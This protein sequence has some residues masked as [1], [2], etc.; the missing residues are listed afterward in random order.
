MRNG[1]ATITAVD[2]IGTTL[3]LYVT[4]SQNLASAQWSALEQ[5]MRTSLCRGN[6]ASMIAQGATVTYHILDAAEEQR[7]FSITSC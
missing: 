3:N 1:P 4:L 7:T 2:A 6:S 5:S